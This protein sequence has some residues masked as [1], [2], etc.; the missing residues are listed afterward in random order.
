MVFAV[1]VFVG[2]GRKSV[3]GFLRLRVLSG[4]KI[5]DVVDFWIS[6]FSEF[7]S[8]QVFVVLWFLTSR[9]LEI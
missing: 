4:L 9:V 7:M 6:R 5:S 3:V 1:C 2:G 8:V